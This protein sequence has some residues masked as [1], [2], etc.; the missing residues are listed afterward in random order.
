MKYIRFPKVKLDKYGCTDLMSSCIRNDV[1]QLSKN[2]T[3]GTDVNFKGYFGETVFMRAIRLG[4]YY[5][6]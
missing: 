1:K 2:L 5:C 3:S 6:R 4:R